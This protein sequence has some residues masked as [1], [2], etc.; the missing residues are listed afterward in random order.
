MVEEDCTSV[1]SSLIYNFSF[2][3]ALLN[4]KIQIFLK[5]V[6]VIETKSLIKLAFAGRS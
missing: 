1:Y 6:K 4:D 2:H 3:I 5:V